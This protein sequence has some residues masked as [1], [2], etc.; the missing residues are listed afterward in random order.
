MRRLSSNTLIILIIIIANIGVWCTFNRGATEQPWG[1]KI[2][3]LSYSGWQAGAAAHSQKT[4]QQ[5]IYLIGQHARS[6]RFYGLSDGLDKL[7][8]EADKI[9]LTVYAGAW[10]GKDKKNNQKELTRL[11]QA[12]QAHKNVMRA[13]IGN[14]TILRKD[15]TVTALTNYIEQAKKQLPI[16]VSTA[17]PW[18]VWLAHP[19]LANAVDF[20]T[21]HIFPYWEGVD[22]IGAL[23]Y[24]DYRMKQLQ[25]AFP[26]KHI[27]L[28]EIG[29]PSE[30]QW[31]KGAEPSQINQAKFTRS[32]LRHA[33][34]NRLDYSIMEAIDA[35]WKRTLEGSVG[36]SWGLWNIDHQPKFEMSGLVVETRSWIW[37]CLAS[38]L[39]A[40]LPMQWFVR[41]RKNIHRRGLF[42]YASIIQ[43]VSSLLI[44]AV[45]TALAEKLINGNVIS[46]FILIGF[47]LILFL[48]L[49]VDGYVLTEVLWSN[50][51]RAF[52]PQD[53]T[54]TQD[55]PKV[56]I[57]VPCYNEPPHMVKQ[58]LDALAA[59]NYPNYEV[60]VVD[61]NTKNESIWKPIEEYCKRLGDKFHFFHLPQWPGYK[62]GALNYALKQT[63][64]DAS[65]IGV[66]DSDYIVDKNWLRAT[67]PYFNKRDVA[68]VQAPQD[69]RDCNG[70]IFKHMCYWEYAGFFHIGMVQRNEQNA[71]IQH[72]TMT[73]IRK[74]NLRNVS[75]WA[76]WC[77]CEDAELGLR[78][79]QSGFEAIYLEHSLGKGL[80]PDSF[81][82]YKTQRFR[83]AYGAVQILKRHWKSLS[84]SADKNGNGLTTGQRYHFVSGWLPWFADATHLVF[85][86]AAIF[87]SC[88]LYFNYVEFPPGVFLI[89]ALS[90]FAFKIAAGLW[91]YHARVTR[92]W[93]AKIGAAIAGMGLSHAVARA[94]W[95]GLFTTE[96]PFIRTPKCEH[97]PAAIQGLMMVRE[98]LILLCLLLIC[99]LVILFKFEPSNRHALLWS[100]MLMV[101]TLPYWA[102]LIM[103]MANVLGDDAKGINQQENK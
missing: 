83:W 75:G 97:Q 26:D 86:V 10:L 6:V 45:M 48:L 96:Q 59:L 3:S 78:L 94:V 103:S 71:I 81:A 49:L 13:I 16:P 65:L 15:I 19:E 20:I 7:I 5:D 54:P 64:S 43:S 53:W 21:V 37:Y 92:N 56:S 41:K 18:H 90:V 66:I 70:S 62:A 30:G 82:G 9:G 1:G 100:G 60:I 84:H 67:I 17:E 8:T 52:T 14:E 69:Y 101:Q 87:W 55:A 28:G 2:S 91:M 12:A 63:A 95:Q 35:P 85:V 99:S 93:K 31:I 27:F 47:Q 24:V 79:F 23:S 40:F 61:N 68:L 11:F 102:A 74:T 4:I 57:H 80:I 72:G 51:Q 88:L 73:L 50:R 34:E 76:E 32:F 22:I 33:S 25:S 46:W 39:L 89:P 58:T 29:W 44:W 98:E 77:I 42:F 38:C 36:A